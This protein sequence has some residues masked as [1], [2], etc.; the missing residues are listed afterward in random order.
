MKKL[1][2]SAPTQLE[3]APLQLWVEQHSR[4]L[5]PGSWMMGDTIIKILV[6]GPGVPCVATHL[7]KAILEF[8]PELMIHLGVAGARH[9]TLEIGDV[10]QVVSEE[11]GDV[12]AMEQD[13]SFSTAFDMGLWSGYEEPWSAEKL[14]NPRRWPISLLPTVAGITVNRIPGSQSEQEDL[15]ARFNFEVESMEGAS[16]FY[17]A[18]TLGTPFFSLR[19]ISNYIEPRDKSR[20]QIPRAVSAVNEAALAGLKAYLD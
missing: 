19:G 10:V 4:P 17:T 13:G 18:L 7:T 11:F 12:G 3:I 9:G 16:V 5:I 15:A 20:W 1:L 2:I 6:S 8:G 14:I